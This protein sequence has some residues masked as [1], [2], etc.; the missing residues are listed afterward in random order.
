LKT[1]RFSRYNGLV[2]EHIKKQHNKTLL[3]FHLFCPVRYR[4]DVFTPEVSKAL[5]QVCKEIEL[6][7]EIYFVE[8]GTDEDHAHFLIQ[9]VPVM[10]SRF[11][12]ITKSITDREI[13]KKHPEVREKL[14]GGKF[15]TSGYYLNTVGSH[16]NEMV[17]RQ[18]VQNQGK[19]Y[20]QL[21]RGQ[22]A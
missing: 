5:T 10:M 15:W 18:Y 2:S 8:I 16:A 7:Y 17:I 12:Q 21:H 13:F 20:T 9:T 3:L 4:K 1:A 14:W 19:T 22:I 11:V 6:R